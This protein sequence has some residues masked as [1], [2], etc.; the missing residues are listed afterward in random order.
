MPRKRFLG[1][2]GLP[3]NRS[4]VKHAVAVGGTYVADC[5][6]GLLKSE[7]MRRLRPLCRQLAVEGAQTCLTT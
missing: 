3:A 7:I 6:P 4:A 2:A 1:R 5:Q